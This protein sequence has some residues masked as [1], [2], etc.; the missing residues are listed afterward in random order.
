ME[1]LE[2]F[3]ARAK[4]AKKTIVLPESSDE[5]TLKAAHLVL[6]EDFAKIILIGKKETLLKR[7]ESLGLDLSRAEFVDSEDSNLLEEFI[8]LFV[9][10]RKYKGM[11][12][13]KAA[14]LLKNPLYFGVALVK[15]KRADGMVAGAINATSD[16][17]RA[18][19]QII[20][21]AQDSKIVSSFFIM[22]VPD[23]EYGYN[24][25]FVFADCGLC[26]NP[27]SEELAYIALDSAKSFQTLLG[28]TPYVGMLSH[29]TYGS[30]SHTDVDKVVQAT[31]LAKKLSPELAL[32]GELQ[33]DAAIVPSVG[34]SKAKGSSVAGRANVLVF[35]DLDSG[36]IGYKL[37]QRLAKAQAYGPITQGLSA[38]VNDLSRGCS[39]E[40]IVGVVAI[41]ALQAVR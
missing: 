6:Q 39:A 17:L 18:S 24:G 31:Q 26:Q 40:D 7:A 23:C 21:K 33:L 19:L 12:S 35:P 29:S 27:S 30:A 14:E 3:K 20:G 16:V 13:Q 38:P 25:G 8:A 37:V 41:T 2:A 28:Q 1:I 34:E 10:L 22:I 11:D 36:N 4:G 5:R 9:E 32:D 15:S